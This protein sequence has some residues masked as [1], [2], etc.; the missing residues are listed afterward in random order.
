M[1]VESRPG[2]NILHIDKNPKCRREENRIEK[3]G[4]DEVNIVEVISL[5]SEERTGTEKRARERVKLETYD[6]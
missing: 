2:M 3:N 4:G 1:K 5:H 6:E